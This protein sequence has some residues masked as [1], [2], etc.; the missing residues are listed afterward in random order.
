MTTPTKTFTKKVTAY[1]CSLIAEALE[2]KADRLKELYASLTD[3]A[4]RILTE[5]EHI[6]VM[7][8]L[9]YF[10]KSSL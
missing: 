2:S 4:E 6:K 9:R 10:L 3:E 1:E 8:L 7:N 5:D